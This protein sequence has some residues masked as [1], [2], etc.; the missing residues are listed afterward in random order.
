[1]DMVKKYV[2][3]AKKVVSVDYPNFKCIVN[4]YQGEDGNVYFNYGNGKHC[5]LYPCVLEKC[6]EQ[7]CLECSDAKIFIVEG[8]GPKIPAYSL[9]VLTF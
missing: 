4:I 6:S 1:M 9:N 8:D 2:V 7:K 3:K 5:P